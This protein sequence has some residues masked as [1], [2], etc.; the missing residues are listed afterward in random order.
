M[1][2][3]RIPNTKLFIQRDVRETPKTDVDLSDSDHSVLKNLSY[4]ASGHTGF[5]ATLT[6]GTGID[7]VGTTISGEDATTA[8]KGIARFDTDHF[9]V[10]DGKVSLKSQTRYWSSPGCAFHVTSDVAD[11]DIIA[12]RLTAGATNIAYA[13]C[14][15]LLPHGAVV[16]SA[17]VC[18]TNTSS[19]WTLVRAGVDSASTST[20]AT[21]NIDSADTSISNATIDNQNYTY[22][23][24]V[25]N[26]QNESING[27]TI[28]YT[29]II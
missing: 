7:I 1:A 8:N 29:I 23:I 15:V 9:T 10:T 4:A 12:H 18:G 3:D 21:D 26:V 2:L 19:T 11:G 24:Y 22:T 20:M 28:T 27:A 6:A 25:G 14:P 13:S 5:Q 17:K 16:T